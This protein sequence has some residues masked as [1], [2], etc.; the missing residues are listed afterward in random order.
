MCRCSSAST[1]APTGDARAD[2]ADRGEHRRCASRARSLMDALDAS[3]VVASISSTTLLEGVALLRPALIVDELPYSPDLVEW[4]AG[5][6]VPAAAAVDA[7]VTLG[8]PDYRRGFEPG[9]ERV[10]EHFF[11]GARGDAAARHAHLVDGL[12]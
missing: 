11:A 9:M 6:Q 8:D 1:L 4:G 12:L 3:F 7:L 2:A 5:L 10:R